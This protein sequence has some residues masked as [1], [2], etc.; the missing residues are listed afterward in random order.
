MSCRHHSA[1]RCRCEGMDH[2]VLEGIPHSKPKEE[3]MRDNTPIYIVDTETTGVNPKLG[4]T[5]FEVAIVDLTNSADRHHWFFQLTDEEIAKA[6]PDCLNGFGDYNGRISQQDWLVKP[7]HRDDAIEDICSVLEDACFAAV[8]PSFDND[9]LRAFMEPHGM[10][11]TW[12][13]HLLDIWTYS[14]PIIGM[15][16]GSK[17]IMRALG[18]PN[19][20]HTAMGDALQER[21]ALLM[22]RAIARERRK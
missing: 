18:L 13:Y 1:F 9:F 16:K 3:V 19:C 14:L 17:D 12:D 21:D 10:Y 11:P 4:H 6:N 7:E 8:N 22:L 15:N 5:I 2:F 20:G